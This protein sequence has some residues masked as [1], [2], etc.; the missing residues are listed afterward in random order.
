MLRF[1]G[2]LRMGEKAQRVEPMVERHDENAA[3]G[4]MRAVIARLGPGADDEPAA[5]DPD[6]RRQ[7]R[8]IVRGGRR[9]DV[10]IKAILGDSGGA[11]V[12]VV[13]EDALQRIWPEGADRAHAGPRRDR[14]RRPP[15]QAPQRRSGIRDALI[16]AHAVCVRLG[17][18]ER[19]AFNRE[20]FRGHSDLQSRFR[21]NREIVGAPAFRRARQSARWNPA[22][23]RSATPRSISPCVRTARTSRP[24]VARR[25][26]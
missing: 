2:E 1:G 10:E 22:P 18:C 26:S 12:D 13:E 6:H 3:R 15:A 4:N 14:L 21:V 20:G 24:S 23:P 9:P 16:G 11:R 8:P 17:D 5:V 25:P 19:A 7:P